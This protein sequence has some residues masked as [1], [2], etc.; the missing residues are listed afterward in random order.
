QLA[1]RQPAELPAH[2]LDVARALEDAGDPFP[3][4]EV[5]LRHDHANRRGL[6]GADGDVCHAL[7]RR[8]TRMSGRRTRET[9]RSC[10]DYA[11]GWEGQRRLVP[12][13]RPRVEL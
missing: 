7:R 8:P 4:V 3:G 10:L 2:E 1:L 9:G 12:T 13:P 6:H 5:S 11:P